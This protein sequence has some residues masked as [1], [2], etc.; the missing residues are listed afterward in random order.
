MCFEQ[1]IQIIQAVLLFGTFVLLFFYT[2]YTYKL[3]KATVEHNE[4]ILRPCITAY[5]VGSNLDLLNIGNGSALNVTIEDYVFK[6]ITADKM[7]INN[8]TMYLKA[9][10]SQNY[11]EAHKPLGVG[12]I[13]YSDNKEFTEFIKTEGIAYFGFPFF[14]W[15]PTEYEL[16]IHYEDIAQNKY[17]SYVT[18]DCKQRRVRLTKSDKVKA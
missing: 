3:K 18:V 17:I 10:I 12:F 13:G 14:F 8:E 11:V 9:D 1:W 15:G 16:K 6:G 5:K 2:C 4:L 7:G